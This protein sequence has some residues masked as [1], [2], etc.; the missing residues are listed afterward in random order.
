MYRIFFAFVQVIAIA[1]Q[2]HGGNRTNITQD[3]AVSELLGVV[4]G[5]IGLEVANE[6]MSHRS[7]GSDNDVSSARVTDEPARR[8]ALAVSAVAIPKPETVH[9]PEVPQYIND[10]FGKC[11]DKLGLNDWCKEVLC[12]Y[13]KCKFGLSLRNRHRTMDRPRP[14]SSLV[15]FV[16]ARTSGQIPRMVS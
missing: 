4:P 11:C 12:V 1:A 7:N 14:S 3:E 15:I 16:I 2:P 8:G 9:M 13:E 10:A 6:T 5:D